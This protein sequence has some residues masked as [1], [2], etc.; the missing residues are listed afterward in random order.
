M[1]TVSSASGATTSI[2]V[3]SIVSQLMT[4]ANKPLDTL[5]VQLS[6][7]NLKISDLGTLKSKLATF[8]SNL[9]TFQSASTYNTTL[10]SSND[11]TIASATSV[12][13]TT[14]GRYSLSISQTAEATNISKTGYSSATDAVILGT[15]GFDLNVNG[16]HYYSNVT[17]VGVNGTTAAITSSSPTLSEVKAWI[18]SLASNS[19]LNLKANVVQT[20]SSS[21]ALVVA[22]T[23]TGLTNSFSFSGLDDADSSA[24]A[25]RPVVV[26]SSARDAILSVNGLSVTRGTNT[27]SDVVSGLTINLLASKSP[28]SSPNTSA[29][30]TVASGTDNSE[31]AIKDL[32]TSYNDLIAQYKSMTKNA[33]TS[34][35]GTIGSFGNATGS[36]S[37]IST[38][39]QMMSRGAT[40]ATGA[41]TSLAYMG[42]DF[43][44]DGTLKFNAESYSTAKGS[45][46]LSTLSNG[47]TVG[48]QGTSNLY[49]SLSIYANPGGLI[50]NTLSLQDNAVLNLTKKQTQLENRLN[51]L[52]T[53]Y[54]TQYSNLNTLLFNLSQTSSQLSSSLSAVTNINSGN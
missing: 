14:V 26:N 52:Q 33:V 13:G 32:I 51:L 40:T 34:S 54:T 39:K 22:G 50:D 30:I 9:D 35:D 2:D 24:I 15:N 4:I 36:L 6:T 16:T 10:A 28:D 17:N 1:A 12:N 23:Q 29:L 27:I 48:K 42:M 45:G 21:Y 49:L 19:N 46:L 8:Q 18:N 37:F 44:V 47:V 20:S 5:K 3:A 38:I 25:A 31:S 41:V 43:Q 11:A 53:Q 7:E